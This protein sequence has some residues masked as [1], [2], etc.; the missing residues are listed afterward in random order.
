MIAP[1]ITKNG[2]QTLIQK[3]NLMFFFNGTQ[4]AIHIWLKITSNA[5]FDE[6]RMP[7]LCYNFYHI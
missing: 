5:Y 4:Y 2:L 3:P 7:L 6:Y 1:N